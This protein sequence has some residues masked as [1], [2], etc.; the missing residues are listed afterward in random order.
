MLYWH[1]VNRVRPTRMGALLEAVER[2]FLPIAER[3]GMRQVGYWQVA[4]GLGTTPETVSVWELDDFGHYVDVVR[5][6]FE[7]TRGDLGPVVRRGGGVGRV[8]R[9]PPVLSVRAHAD[10][11]AD[12]GA[13]PAGEAV[14]ARDDPRAAG[15]SGGVSAPVRGDVVP[16]RRR[17]GGTF[18]RRPLLVAVEE[19]DGR[20]ASGARG[21]SG[22]TSTRSA[23]RRHG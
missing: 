22:R 11:R 14:L 8:K 18:H 12:Q 5:Q 10:G 4:P 15:P 1:E 9:E 16:P 21:K 2:D 7:G 20:S 13:K 6:R 3:Y 17:A 23:R 19:H